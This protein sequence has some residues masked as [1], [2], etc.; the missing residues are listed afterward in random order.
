MLP[1]SSKKKSSS[2]TGLTTLSLQDRSFPRSIIKGSLIHHHVQELQG[3]DQEFQPGA[4][5]NIPKWR[6]SL[7]PL[8]RIWVPCLRSVGIYNKTICVESVMSTPAC[9][10]FGTGNRKAIRNK[11]QSLPSHER[12]Y[13]FT[14]CFQIVDIFYRPKPTEISTFEQ[15]QRFQASFSYTMF[16]SAICGKAFCSLTILHTN[17]SSNWSVHILDGG[18]D[19]Y[20]HFPISWELGC[21][22]QSKEP[23]NR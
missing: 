18:P 21:K 9:N 7:L 12:R 11:N 15:L 14:S 5:L 1:Q 17:M 8:A 13:S 10:T 4:T 19:I 23:I 3:S 2:H 22:E 6:R 16:T 20:V